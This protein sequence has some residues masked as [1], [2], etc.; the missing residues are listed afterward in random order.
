M[1]LKVKGKKLSGQVDVLAY[2]PD[3]QLLVML[4]CKVYELP[5][6]PNQMRN[7]LNK[8]GS[9]DRK[10]IH[11][12]LDAKLEWVLK[13]DLFADKELNL[14]RGLMLDRKFPGMYHDDFTVM[15]PKLFEE[16]LQELE[17]V[18]RIPVRKDAIG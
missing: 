18:E 6:S 10:K 7:L 9:G 4:E 1:P 13:S 11:K 5:S 2:K 15:D 3:K 17:E 14:F 12:D 8:F 16:V